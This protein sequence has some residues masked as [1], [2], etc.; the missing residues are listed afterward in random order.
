M[1][2]LG[3]GRSTG[4]TAAA[5][6]RHQASERDLAVVVGEAVAG[7]DVAAAIRAHAGSELVGLHLDVYRGSPLG[8]DEK[9]LAYRLTFRAPDRSLEEARSTPRSRRSRPGFIPKSTDG[10]GPES[11]L[12]PRIR[13]CY[14]VPRCPQRTATVIP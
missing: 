10:S 13:R 7:G 9:S 8:P 2:G 4:V 12:R 11:C 6:P 1:T 14:P 5:P 3:G